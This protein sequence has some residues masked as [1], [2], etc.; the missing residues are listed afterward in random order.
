MKTVAEKI[1]ARIRADLKVPAD[2]VDSLAC[3]DMHPIAGR[4]DELPCRKRVVG[5]VREFSSEADLSVSAAFRVPKQ[6]TG[7]V[8]GVQPPDR[9]LKD[10]HYVIVRTGVE[11]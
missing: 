8:V 5:L 11:R 10:I 3:L 1:A 9:S 7:F 6:F 2:V 4:S